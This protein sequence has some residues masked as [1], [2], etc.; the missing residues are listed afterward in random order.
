MPDHNAA[1]ANYGGKALSFEHIDVTTTER[2]T[3]ITLNR[4]AVLNAINAPMTVED[5]PTPSPRAGEVLL[6]I[7]GARR[8]PHG[9]TRH[10]RRSGVSDAMRPR[11]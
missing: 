11:P 5:L 4:P 2:I 8:L 7:A 3:R 10:A 6:R 9:P 1:P